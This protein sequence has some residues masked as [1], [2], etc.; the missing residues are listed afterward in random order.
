MGTFIS[1]IASYSGG[2]V[3]A[4]LLRWV[5]SRFGGRI[6]DRVAETIKSRRDDKPGEG[7]K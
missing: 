1:L 4:V 7:A 3:G 5:L 6:L 2:K